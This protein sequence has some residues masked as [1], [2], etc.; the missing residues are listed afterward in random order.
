MN[1]V[2]GMAEWL[3]DTEL[4]PEQRDCAD[5][6][7]T[8]GEALLSIINDIL[9]FSKMD[10]D[11]LQLEEEDFEVRQLLS[12]VV[13]PFQK[14]A[15]SKGLALSS[16]TEPQVPAWLRGDAARLR[17][18]LRHLLD[19]AVKFTERGTIAVHVD[20][21]EIPDGKSPIDLNLTPSPP[22]GVRVR[23]AISDTGIGIASD[24]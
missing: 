16:L 14:R 3:L 23:C 21:E 7:R 20:M 12:D 15:S 4:T 11:K 24:A 22:Q 17:Q 13:G 9:D 5:T 1:G 19:N 18:I 10:S 8:S 6:I 2:L